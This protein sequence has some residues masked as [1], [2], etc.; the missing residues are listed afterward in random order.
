MV[1]RNFIITP[2]YAAYV[3]GIP[4]ISFYPSLI[5]A[6]IVSILIYILFAFIEKN[7]L[8]D[9]WIKLIAICGVSALIGYVLSFI[10]LLNKNEKQQF[11]SII[12]SRIYKNKGK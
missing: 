9:S 8:I 2:V 11:K 3:L 4:L 7:T 12:V 10:L 1:I 6:L 5:K